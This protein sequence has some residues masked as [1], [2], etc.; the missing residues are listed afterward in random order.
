MGRSLG[1][2]RSFRD[3]GD[4]PGRGEAGRTGP[5]GLSQAEVP[6]DLLGGVGG[7]GDWRGAEGAGIYPPG[8]G[9]PSLEYEVL[10]SQGWA[11]PPVMGLV[12]LGPPCAHDW[13]AG[14]SQKGKLHCKVRCVHV[15]STRRYVL[16]N[17]ATEMGN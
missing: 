10:R 13:P 17:K 3:A 8:S 2:R 5:G 15:T 1:A 12:S 7:F 4:G 14:A 9:S 6:A 16:E 11:L